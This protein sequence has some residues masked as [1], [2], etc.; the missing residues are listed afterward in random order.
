MNAIQDGIKQGRKFEQVVEGARQV[1]LRDGFEGANVDDIAKA[2]GVSKATLY[3]YFPD[4]RVLFVEIASRECLRQADE[5]M[6]TVDLDLPPREVLA[7]AGRKLIDFMLSDMGKAIFRIS[8]GESDRFPEIGRKFYDSG[9]GL[10]RERLGLYLARAVERGELAIDDLALA[11]DQFAELCKASVF[12]C[13]IFGLKCEFTDE[14]R[15][16]VINAAVDM[17]MARYGVNAPG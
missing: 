9:P 15:M 2:A 6:T 8:V 12:P 4:K 14:E 10:V 7:Y 16:R 17:F 11:A 1:F 5:H 13:C 3:S